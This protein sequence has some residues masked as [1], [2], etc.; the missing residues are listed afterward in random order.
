MSLG[1]LC[2]L[3]G[4][5]G[6]LG[7][8]L[9]EGLLKA[10]YRVRC[11]VR[12]PSRLRWLKGLPVELVKGDVC[13]PD[14]ASEALEGAELVIHAAGLT[15]AVDAEAYYRVNYRGTVHLAEAVLRQSHDLW[16]FLFVSSLAAVGPNRDAAP[17]TEDTEP[18]PIT[19]YGQ[20]KLWAERALC[21]VMD[22]VP[23]TIVRPPVIYGPRDTDGLYLARIAAKGVVPR[24]RPDVLLSLVYVDDIVEG[25]LKALTA[26]NAVGRTYHMVGPE[27]APLSRILG[28]VARMAGRRPITLPVP[29]QP[30]IAVAF[31]VHLLSRVRGH[32]SK[33]SHY[34]VRE[35]LQLGWF[36]SYR[37][38]EEELGYS[39]RFGLEEGLS[40]TLAWYREAGYL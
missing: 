1:P 12:D 17:L 18:R 32:I 13:D 40:R 16:R 15:K 20:S 14:T 27:T 29:G 31:L 33:V 23:V 7:S 26:P 5:T 30:L 4:G 10:G 25:I 37:R 2:L 6:F 28:L 3:T 9:A 22:R 36:A 34:K 24:F 35:I 38:A 11:L 21:S 39:P 8:H 19:P